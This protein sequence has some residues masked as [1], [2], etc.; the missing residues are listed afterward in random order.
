MTFELFNWFSQTNTKY[1]NVNWDT[2]IVVTGQFP[3]TWLVVTNFKNFVMPYQ[4][5]KLFGHIYVPSS[6]KPREKL[7]QGPHQGRPHSPVPSKTEP[8]LDQVGP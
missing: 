5:Y 6:L 1:K 4:L 3:P 8:S 7:K 2:G